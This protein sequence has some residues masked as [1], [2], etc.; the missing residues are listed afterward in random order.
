MNNDLKKQVQD[1]LFEAR[2]PLAPLYRYFKTKYGTDNVTM[3]S[4]EDGFDILKSLPA[5]MESINMMAE[6]ENRAVDDRVHRIK[7]LRAMMTDREKM[8]IDAAYNKWRAARAAADSAP[9]GKYEKENNTANALWR[10]AS[11]IETKILA[12]VAARLDGESENANT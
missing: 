1:A 7:M 6:R 11:A 8:T 12:E 3:L 2:V 9:Y 4:D 10:V 5:I